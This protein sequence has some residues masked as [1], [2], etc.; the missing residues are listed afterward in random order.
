AAPVEPVKYGPIRGLHVTPYF[1]PAFVYG[2]PPRSVL[3]L[4]RALRRAGARVDVVT[5]TANGSAELPPAVTEVATFDGVPVTY[6]PR[7]FPKQHFRAAA[8]TRVLDAHAGG[9][10]LGHVHGCWNR[11]GLAAARWWRRLGTAFVGS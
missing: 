11:F 6:V 3:G 4:C 10:D 8:L 7:S 9:C 2:G 5:T 1:A